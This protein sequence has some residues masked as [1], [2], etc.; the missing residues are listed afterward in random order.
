MLIYLSIID[1]EEDIS[2]FELIYNTYKNRMHHI[3]KDIL[4]DVHI[5][6][7]A[8][9]MA[10]LRIVKNLDKIG[11]VDSDRTKSLVSK[12]PEEKD[13]HHTFSDKFEN[14]MRDIINSQKDTMVMR[15]NYKKYQKIAVVCLIITM[16]LITVTMNVEALRVK[17]IDIVTEIYTELTSFK[18]KKEKDNLDINLNFVEPKYI[19]SGFKEIDRV[20]SPIGKFIV[21][22][23][24]EYRQIRY[25]CDKIENNS[26]II[27]TE[28]ATIEDININGYDAK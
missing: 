11:D 22:E 16:G 20:E 6:E 23:N 18:F 21:Y 25:S 9:H 2:K 5:S 4:K 13:I 12:L 1:S 14:N 24:D 26:V 17:V 8:V 7:D 27:D 3:A 15:S 19:P 28:N 10:F